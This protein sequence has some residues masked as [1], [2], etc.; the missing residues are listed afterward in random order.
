MGRVD[1]PP[2]ET[3]IDGY[4]PPADNELVVTIVKD[5][6]DAEEKKAK[7]KYE[8]FA[9]CL[10]VRYLTQRQDSTYLSCRS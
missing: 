6:T 2:P 10:C 5:W 4:P 7:R 8:A 1:L 3:A 9:I